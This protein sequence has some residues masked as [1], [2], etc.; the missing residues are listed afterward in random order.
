MLFRPDTLAAIADGRI[1]LAYRRWERPR[2]R[3]GGGQRT[4]IGVIGFQGVEAVT[5]EEV[6]DDDARRAGFASRD[7][8]L[9]FLDRKAAGSIYRVR[10]RLSGPDPR[11]AL[12]EAVPDE[13]E[14]ADIE[15]RLARLDALSS[16]G[17]WTRAVLEAIGRQ[18]GR[19]AAD[20]AEAF[21][22][23]RLP[24]KMDVRKLK[25][26]GLTES[27][28]VGYRLSPRGQAVL[29]RLVVSDAEPGPAAPR[30]RPT[31]PPRRAGR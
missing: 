3:Q 28:P 23:E 8:L 30:R 6:T 15:R 19:R 18:P 29:Q 24:F 14:A 16:H 25:E 13:R 5:R 11:V 7:E 2:V 31:R 27:L 22:R 9:S 26:L 17:P 4:P 21:G 20:L 12:R 1:D 10:L